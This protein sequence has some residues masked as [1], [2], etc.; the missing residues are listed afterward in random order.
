MWRRIVL[1]LVLVG[2]GDD[3]PGTTSDANPGDGRP[4]SD[5]PPSSRTLVWF[6]DWR[7]GTGTAAA[8]LSDGG[9]FNDQLCNSDVISVVPA[10]GLEFPTTNVLR[11]EYAQASLCQ[12]RRARDQWRLTEVGESLFVRLYYR[13][14]MPEGRLVG[15]P[16]PLHIGEGTPYAMWFTFF[17]PSGGTA[18]MT[19]QLAGDH[20]YPNR[21]WSY[22]F[23][24][25]ETFRLE[26]RLQRVT[27]TT[28][29][30]SVRS[31]DASGALIADS[32]DWTNGESG[33]NL[34]SLTTS[35]PTVPVTDASFRLLDIGNN[36]PGGLV[37]GADQVVY[38]GGVAVAIDAD[39][40]AW[41]G[42]YPTAS[43]A[44]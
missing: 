1:A 29:K 24:T 28:A 3:G 18:P 25:H 11:V 19:L 7:T 13:N 33:P 14:V 43:E 4:A 42:P 2:C 21:D 44:P 34:R 35:D 16:H 20:V 15:V 10:T 17:A 36:D 5:A 30:A 22:R 6:A 37:A 39:P 9:K 31:Y 41:I 40:E 12:M 23:T 26:L 27:A 8:A 38:F 32:D